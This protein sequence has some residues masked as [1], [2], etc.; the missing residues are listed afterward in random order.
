MIVVDDEKIVYV[1]GFPM[2]NLSDAAAAFV[3]GNSPDAIPLT[4]GHGTSTVIAVRARNL[5]GVGGILASDTGGS[6][7]TDAANWTCT[8]SYQVCVNFG[9]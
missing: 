2:T 8:N 7:T 1:D 3:C 5:A 4:V 9:I 6:F